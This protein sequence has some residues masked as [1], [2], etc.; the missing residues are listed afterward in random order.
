MMQQQDP[1]QYFCRRRLR[2]VGPFSRR[3]LLALL[4]AGQIDASTLIRK[5]GESVL[6]PLAMSEVAELIPAAGQ[7][8]SQWAT[9]WR[10]WRTVL[11][12]P[13]LAG[14]MLHLHAICHLPP[15][16]GPHL[17]L[18]AAAGGL[19]WWLYQLWRMALGDARPQRALIHALPLLIPLV[20][21]FW[22][23]IGYFGLGRYLKV[24]ARR[25]KLAA[26]SLQP[27]FLAAIFL[28]YLAVVGI[29]G[30]WILPG[31]Q[32][33]PVI[34][35][36]VF[37]TMAWYVVTVVSL[38]AADLL[39][40]QLLRVRVEKMI[41]SLLGIACP[42][43]YS[44][45]FRA[46][47]LLRVRV[48]KSTQVAALLIFGAAVIPQIRL[49]YCEIAQIYTRDF[50]NELPSTP[51]VSSEV[52]RIAAV[53]TYAATADFER[54]Q[55]EHD[56]K[57]GMEALLRLAGAMRF[58]LEEYQSPVPLFVLQYGRLLLRDGAC[59]LEAPDVTE[60]DLRLLLRRVRYEEHMVRRT[61]LDA[62][63]RYARTTLTVLP[64][65][66]PFAVNAAME[67]AVILPEYVWRDW[68][69]ILPELELPTT[70]EARSGAA[71]RQPHSRLAALR[72]FLRVNSMLLYLRMLQSAIA[73]R[74]YERKHGRMPDNLRELVPGWLAQWPRNPLT[75]E[76][77][78]YRRDQASGAAGPLRFRL[79]AGTWP[80]V[81]EVP[82]REYLAPEMTVMIPPPNP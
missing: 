69:E 26:I 44:T 1:R 73:I 71:L 45:L 28:Y 76:L 80:G 75:G 11:G 2:S 61:A 18:L 39:V 3:E 46:E 70:A 65:E 14:M 5:T 29:L 57:G 72:F 12:W 51:T 37:L 8:W 6:R 49:D 10:L 52:Y 62:V 32:K 21:W 63:H 7:I 30:R 38:I 74:L 19:I 68:H 77:L 36:V 33:L 27:L 64:A 31:F 17:A 56:V 24:S 22:V 43:D 34:Y 41:G 53:R 55:L 16:W 82:C 4:A 9:P 20:G 25:R 78:Q 81:A 66:R 40:M 47:A 50:L 48:R 79:S 15:V 67:T 42:V 23:W 54:A 59:L 35:E 58:S 13:L 60:A